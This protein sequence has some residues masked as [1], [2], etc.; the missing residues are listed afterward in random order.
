MREK[1]SCWRF[2]TEE[3]HY[4]W[5]KVSNKI[6]FELL[7]SQIKAILTVP[8]I[9]FSPNNLIASTQ[10]KLMADHEAGN[11]Y[12]TRLKF[13]IFGAIKHIL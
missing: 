10:I 5:Q 8:S 12:L 11:V 4:A 3:I 6:S 13:M 1:S 7:F 2:R 9:A